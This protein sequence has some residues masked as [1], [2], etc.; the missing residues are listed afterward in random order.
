MGYILLGSVQNEHFN[1]EGGGMDLHNI[2]K[3]YKKE[4]FKYFENNKKLHSFSKEINN[5]K[6]TWF[7]DGRVTK[8]GS[9]IFKLQ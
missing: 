8:G 2:E 4:C 5:R 7:F 1:Y 9:A 3:E 6:C